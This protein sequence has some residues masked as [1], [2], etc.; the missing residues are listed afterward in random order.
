MARSTPSS[1]QRRRSAESAWTRATAACK[2]ARTGIGVAAGTKSACQS[3]I[4][5][6]TPISRQV[7]TSGAVGLRRGPVTAK[8]RACPP[9]AVC[10]PATAASNTMAIRPAATSKVAGAPPR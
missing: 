5:A 9:R 1:A 4:S 2:A 10:R 6:S 3:C 8:A 7:G